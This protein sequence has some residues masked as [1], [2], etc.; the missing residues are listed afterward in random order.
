MEYY[1]HGYYPPRAG[2]NKMYLALLDYIDETLKGLLVDAE[3][4]AYIKVKLLFL[5]SNIGEQHPN[6]KRC[7]ISL[8]TQGQ[9][10]VI[11]IDGEIT[12]ILE[13]VHGRQRRAG[14]DRFCN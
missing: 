5:Q 4:V 1:I 12:A 11:A 8:E 6:W 7:K 2:R 9:G 14:A 3:Q 10:Y 13:P